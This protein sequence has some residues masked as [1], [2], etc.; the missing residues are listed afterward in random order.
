MTT[1][2]DPSL[3][4]LT[5][6][7]TGNLCSN[8]LPKSPNPC[9]TNH[10]LVSPPSSPTVY[11]KFIH[12]KAGPRATFPQSLTPDIYSGSPPHW[13]GGAGRRRAIPI[14]RTLEKALST[15]HVTRAH[16]IIPLLPS[17]ATFLLSKVIENYPA[18]LNP[19]VNSQASLALL[20]VRAREASGAIS[21]CFVVQ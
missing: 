21:V 20:G 6:S 4:S 11:R 19:S 15:A 1:C 5:K 2:L 12:P 7:G 10:F 3:P 9:N 18:P 8:L 17:T 13:G 16:V 14:A